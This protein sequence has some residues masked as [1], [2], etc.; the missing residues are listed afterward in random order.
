MTAEKTFANQRSQKTIITVEH[1]WTDKVA[2]LG[3]RRSNC[4][5][6]TNSAA[7]TLMFSPNEAAAQLQITAHQLFGGSKRAKFIVWKPKGARYLSAAIRSKRLNKLRKETEIM[8]KYETWIGVGIKGGGTLFVVGL[9]YLSGTIR[10]LGMLTEHNDFQVLGPR[11]GL[12][13]GGGA[14][15]VACMVFHCLNI[16]NLNDT[17]ASDWSIN[18]SLGAK[19][20]GIVKGLANYNFFA[21]IGKVGTVL[22]AT[23]SD[24]DNLRNGMS[25]F[26]AFCDIASMNA[27]PKLVTIDVPGAGVGM[28]LSAHW[29]TGKIEILD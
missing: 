27:S 16:N 12:G 4:L 20:D 28:E 8:D 13:L 15:V 18:A 23:P 25:Y 21:T 2:A 22:K 14:G 3:E 7:E 29:T 11:F 24:I 9:E 17:D 1:Y 10:N 26:Y 6:R 5:V 19:W